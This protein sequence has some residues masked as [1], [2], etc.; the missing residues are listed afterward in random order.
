[1]WVYNIKKISTTFQKETVKSN[2]GED[3]VKVRDLQVY[4]IQNI[5]SSDDVDK[6]NIADRLYKGLDF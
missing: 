1:M 3:L 5:H 6:N 4:R 2:L